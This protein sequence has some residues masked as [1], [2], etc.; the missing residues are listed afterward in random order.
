MLFC[1]FTL[2]NR[3]IVL[4]KCFHLEQ[5]KRETIKTRGRI[6]NIYDQSRT[7]P[8]LAAHVLSLWDVF[9]KKFDK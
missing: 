8:P 9:Q 4:F 1:A 6:W 2:K 3:A 7:A 5:D